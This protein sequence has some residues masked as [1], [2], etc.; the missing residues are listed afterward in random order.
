MPFVNPMLFGTSGAQGVAIVEF[1]AVYETG[2]PLGRIFLS[3]ENETDGS[4]VSDPDGLFS[5]Y[6]DPYGSD[7][8]SYNFYG[9]Y[10]FTLIQNYSF[11]N[12]LDGVWLSDGNTNSGLEQDIFQLYNGSI[13]TPSPVTITVDNDAGTDHF[14][15]SY[16]ISGGGVKQAGVTLRIKVEYLG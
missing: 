12:N 10:R 16:T 6:T 11:F 15:P 8:V 5:I 2:T 13:L 9:D 3:P 14:K 7:L 1:N 4:I